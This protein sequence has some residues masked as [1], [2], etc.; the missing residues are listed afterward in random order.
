V[1]LV[2]D[3]EY[4]IVARIKG[5]KVL[6]HNSRV[7]ICRWDGGDPGRPIAHGISR[8]GRRLEKRINAERDLAN[9]RVAWVPEHLR[10]RVWYRWDK[11]RAWRECLNWQRAI[12]GK[13]PLL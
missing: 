9:I 11:S 12:Q 13:G 7:Y 6:R 5:D 4:G 10:E 2:G 8:G 1:G 3:S